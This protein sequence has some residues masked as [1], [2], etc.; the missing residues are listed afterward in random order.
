ELVFRAFYRALDTQVD[1]SGLGLAIVKEIATRHDTTVA[2]ADARPRA[3]ASQAGQGPWA[4][5][6]LRFP[7]VGAPPAG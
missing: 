7:L 3:P 2:V 1:G 6:T 4:L 5:F